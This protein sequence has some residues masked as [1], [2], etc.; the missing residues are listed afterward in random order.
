MPTFR[1]TTPVA[2]Q[3]WW[4][5]LV[6]WWQRRWW[7]GRPVFCLACHVRYVLCWSE[8]SL[9]CMSCGKRNTLVMGCPGCGRMLYNAAFCGACGYEYAPERPNALGMTGNGT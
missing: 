6:L 7:R 3:V 2:A 9:H 8:S 1:V 4:S 5:R